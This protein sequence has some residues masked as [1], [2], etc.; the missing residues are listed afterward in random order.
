L[1]PKA[2]HDQEVLDAFGDEYMYLACIKFIN[3]VSKRP[4][5]LSEFGGCVADLIG[6]V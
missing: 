6:V 5:S 2:I 4:D 3:G 1:K